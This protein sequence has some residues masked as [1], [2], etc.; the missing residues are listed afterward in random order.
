MSLTKTLAAVL[1]VFSVAAVSIAEQFSFAVIPDT[2]QDI[3][4]NYPMMEHRMNWL[5]DNKDSMNLKWVLSSGDYIDWDT[6]DHIHYQRGSDAM[7]I[8]EAA[9][10]PFIIGFGNHDSLAVC[11]GGSACPG[12][13]NANLRNTSLWNVYFPVGRF[14]NLQGTYE[15]DKSE[16]AYHAFQAGGL[17]WMIVNIEL[18]ARSGAIEWAKSVVAAHPNHNVIVVMHSYL[19]SS[20]GILNSNGGYGNNTP[21]H[22]YDTWISRYPNIKMVFSGHTGQCAHRTDTGVNGNTIHSILQT[23]HDGTNNVTR[24]VEVDTEAGSFSTYVY[25][26]NTDIYHAPAAFSVTGVEWVQPADGI[27]PDP[28]PDPAPGPGTTPGA[29]PLAD[30]TVKGSVLRENSDVV[31]FEGVPSLAVLSIYT[32]TGSHVSTLNESDFSGG[33]IDWN[34]INSAAQNVKPGVYIYVLADAQ[35]NRKSGKVVIGY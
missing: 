20:G 19:T 10:I 25:A 34:G 15:T 28:E 23:Y 6:P 27:D 12:D 29:N 13:V 22:M 32:L 3:V 24:I 17:D 2:Q 1:V 26:P 8:L 31:R 9:G 18:W 5:A 7:G 30:V 35:G 33:V 16:N 11:P 21:Q 4:Y 14:T